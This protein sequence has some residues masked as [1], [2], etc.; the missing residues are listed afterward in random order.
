[1]IE[2]L[3]WTVPLAFYEHGYV[4]RIEWLMRHVY[5]KKLGQDGLGFGAP[6]N[7]NTTPYDSACIWGAN[8][9][10]NTVRRHLWDK[11]TLVDGVAQNLRA[12]GDP[13][14]FAGVGT[15]HY[16]PPAQDQAR[17]NYNYGQSWM[18]VLPAVTSNADDWMYNFPNLTGET[19][20][21]SVNEWP[22]TSW[23]SEQNQCGYM[24]WFNNHLPRV[25]GRAA[26]GDDTGVLLNWWE[27]AIN[28]NDYP[29]TLP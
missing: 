8:A 25:P 3:D 21:I 16:T 9:S 13:G 15:A 10:C 2:F 24:L 12:H 26:S 14:A 27:Y 11:F 28:F 19:R 22:A 6:S 1:M 17:D 29:E 23:C 18:P 5:F 7:W 20:S 4:H